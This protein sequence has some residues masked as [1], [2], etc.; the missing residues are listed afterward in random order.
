MST[1]VL[2]IADET[3]KKCENC[4]A[5]WFDDEKGKGLVVP[6]GQ[7]VRHEGRGTGHAPQF[8]SFWPVPDN[9]LRV[10]ATPCADIL[11]ELE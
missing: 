8:T 10:D 7:R 3:G 9:V 4:E 2:H 11:A 6:E 5:R 1:A